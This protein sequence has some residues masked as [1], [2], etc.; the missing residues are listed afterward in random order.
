MGEPEEFIPLNLRRAYAKLSAWIS[1]LNRIPEGPRLPEPT[2]T[3]ALARVVP[4]GRQP[5]PPR[6]DYQLE[7]AASAKEFANCEKHR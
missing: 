2:R 6:P 4:L 3:D 1:R 5:A 7:A